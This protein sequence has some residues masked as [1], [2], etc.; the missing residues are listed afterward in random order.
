M[1]TIAYA[2]EW[3]DEARSRSDY[4]NARVEIQARATAE[5][6][7]YLGTITSVTYS[8]KSDRYTAKFGGGSSVKVSNDVAEYLLTHANLGGATS[9]PLP[10]VYAKMDNG[11]I[12]RVLL[13][14]VSRS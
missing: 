11:W 10:T 7:M 12:V 1:N 9:G 8:D 6:P 14:F 2:S 13:L 5:T 3:L 4:A